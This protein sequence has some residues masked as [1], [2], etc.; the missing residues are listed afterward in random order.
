MLPVTLTRHPVSTLTPAPAVPALE[1]FAKKM[2]TLVITLF[3]ILGLCSCGKKQTADAAP[4]SN[5]EEYELKR[6]VLKDG[7]S[8]MLMMD[9]DSDLKIGAAVVDGRLSIAEIDPEGRNFGVTWKDSE[10]WETSTIISDGS[11]TG[12]VLDKDG[13][14]Y[15]DFKAETGPSGTRRYKLEGEAWIEVKSKKTESEQAAPSNR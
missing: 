6:I 3:S 13:D 15:A 10:T 12:Y 1:T 9:G 11:T 5:E 8:V 4:K 7:Q 14:G 2:K